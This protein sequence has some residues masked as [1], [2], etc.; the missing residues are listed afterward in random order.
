VEE[1]LDVVFERQQFEGVERKGDVR[2]EDRLSVGH[3]NSKVLCKQKTEIS[4]RFGRLLTLKMIASGLEM[5]EVPLN[6]RPATTCGFTI[7][8]FCRTMA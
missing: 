5:K 2:E 4:K 8:S 6:S 1:V 3:T 7:P